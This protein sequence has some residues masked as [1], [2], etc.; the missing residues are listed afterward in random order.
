MHPS[1]LVDTAAA[2]ACLVRVVVVVNGSRQKLL[3]K[4]QRVGLAIVDRK[5]LHMKSKFNCSICLYIHCSCGRRL[6]LAVV[7]RST[8]W[9]TDQVESTF[10]VVSDNRY[11]LVSVRAIGE[12]SSENGCQLASWATSY[13]CNQHKRLSCGG[14]VVGGYQSSG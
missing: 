2:S 9:R 13:P 6:R 14:M 3:R 12:M 8:Q 7:G 11:T 10:S 1:S 4:E 5:S